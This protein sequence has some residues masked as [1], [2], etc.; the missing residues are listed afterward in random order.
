MR[1]FKPIWLEISLEKCVDNR[2]DT[3]DRL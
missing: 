3:G 2:T 1:M